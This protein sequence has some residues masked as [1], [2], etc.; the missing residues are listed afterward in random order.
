[1]FVENL[2]KFISKLWIAKICKTQCKMNLKKR[3]K[4]IFEFHGF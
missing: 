2:F 4:K 3:M 1:M